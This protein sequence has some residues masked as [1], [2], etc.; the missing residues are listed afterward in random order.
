MIEA[1]AEDAHGS[2]GAWYVAE[3]ARVAGH[4]V[5]VLTQPARGYDVELISVHH[6]LDFERL[7]VMDKGARHRI[8]GG[9]V[10]GN[11]PR[12]A[13]PFAD[14]ICVGEGESWI[15]E[16][17]RRIEQYDDVATLHDMPG[18]I[19]GAGWEPGAP[20]PAS[21]TERPLPNNDPYL[22]RPGTRS[23]AW[24]VEIARGCP[25]RCAFCELGHSVPF[26]LYDAEHLKCVL[27]KADTKITRKINFYAP[28]EASHPQ[29]AVLYAYL[30]ER[31]YAAG[32]SSMRIDSILRNGLPDIKTNVLIRVGIDGLSEET[33]R[34]VNKPITDD[35]IV[36]YFRRF[37][38]RGHC[39]FKMFFIYGFPWETLADFDHFETLMARLFALPLK[40]NLSLRLKWTP[41]IPQPCTPLAHAGAQYDF[42]MVDRINVWH[43]LNAR[44]RREPGWFIENDGMMGPRN[45]KR[46]CDLTAGDERILLRFP[47]AKPLHGEK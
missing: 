19:L 35:M 1:C 30:R 44:P 43:A 28:D 31:G 34:R 26:R 32:F 38:E 9:H 40:K 18:T 5:D 33:R 16:A 15:G 37:I 4:T 7:A 42:D 20:V 3:K 14:A 13:I 23:A 10:M 24:Y 45:H 25:Y 47:G 2:I 36:E 29:Y 8:V 39:Q 22:N 17:L 11:N 6:C 41:F 21:N 46:Q 27:A 12:P